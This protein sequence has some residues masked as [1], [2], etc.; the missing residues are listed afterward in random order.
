MDEDVQVVALDGGHDVVVAIA[1]DGEGQRVGH[2]EQQH[3]VRPAPEVVTQ[4]V[5]G[6]AAGRKKD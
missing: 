5:E 2:Q 6:T 3:H 1:Y 4:V